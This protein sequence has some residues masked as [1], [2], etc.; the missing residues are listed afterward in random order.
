MSHLVK[1]TC[2]KP[3]TVA[4]DATCRDNTEL[5]DLA[6]RIEKSVGGKR[7]IS[8]FSEK[9]EKKSVEVLVKSPSMHSVKDCVGV[10]IQ[11][12]GALNVVKDIQRFYNNLHEEA[13]R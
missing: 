10:A 11:S 3:H 12:G 4:C 9:E 2:P 6:L 5:V 1:H 8:E 13:L 7:P